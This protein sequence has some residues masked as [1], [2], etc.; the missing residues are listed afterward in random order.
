MQTDA[1]WSWKLAPEAGTMSADERR[2][3]TPAERE[4]RTVFRQA[5]AEKAMSDHE[6]AEEA[7]HKNRERLKADRLAREAAKGEPEPHAKHG[8][9]R[10]S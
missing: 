4:A 10:R 5:E 3:L 8:R 2:V 1:T 7:F 9:R 6:K